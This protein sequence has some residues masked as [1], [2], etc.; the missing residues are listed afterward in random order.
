MRSLFASISKQAKD[1]SIMSEQFSRTELLLGND[2]LE[3]LK[4]SRV[5]VFGIG[6]V[7]SYT[8]EILARG[9]V[10]TVDIIDNDTVSI[11]NINRQLI[12]LHSTVGKPKVVAEKERLLDINPEMT[13]NTYQLFY[14]PETAG[15]FDFSVYDYIVDAVD[16][17]SAKILLVEQA[18]KANVPI[19]SSMGTGNKLK[20]EMLEVSD[21]SKTSVCPLA[22]VMR[23][24][25]KKR[26]IC[27]LKVVYSKEQ[28]IKPSKQE[29]HNGR[30]IPA[31]TPFVPAT[32]GILIA[33]EVIKEITK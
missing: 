30:H 32:A 28:P 1:N 8:A 2:S 15:Q 18:K 11:S 24:E 25:L 3:K 22:R 16:T 21:I 10:G 5:A 9:G 7:G 23:T 17:V 14:M 19:I 20:P 4:N 27:K 6:G 26:G 13:V 33:A 29:E 12:A 31:S